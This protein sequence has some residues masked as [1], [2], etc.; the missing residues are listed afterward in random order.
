[1]QWS[2]NSTYLDAT[3]MHN[4]TFYT[5]L[6]MGLMSVNNGKTLSEYFSKIHFLPQ[7]SYTFLGNLKIRM[8]NH[9]QIYKELHLSRV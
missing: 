3:V 8:A 9:K 4:I 6:H 2:Y 5:H 1:M 7:I